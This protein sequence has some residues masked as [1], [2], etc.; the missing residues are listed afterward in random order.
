MSDP[1]TANFRSGFAI[2]GQRQASAD[3]HKDSILARRITAFDDPH[4]QAEAVVH[5]FLFRPN[6]ARRPRGGPGRR[7]CIEG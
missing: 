6:L 5:Y 3:L 7:S 1:V 4:W 2:W